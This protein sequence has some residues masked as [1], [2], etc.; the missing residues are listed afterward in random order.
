MNIQNNQLYLG[1]I[2][3]W[4]IPILEI[5][6]NSIKSFLENKNTDCKTLF[7]IIHPVKDFNLSSIL[8]QV[9]G[10]QDVFFFGE[11]P[12]E[13]FSFLG[14]DSVYDINI[15]GEERV[16]ETAEVVTAV[17]KNFVNNWKDYDLS[18][19]L[20][21]G[22]M[23]F[24][25]DKS[26]ELWNEFSDSDW[27]IPKFLFLKINN[28]PFLAYNILGN[29]CDDKRLQDDLNRASEL[30]NL[31]NL[32][33]SEI[34]NSII[35]TNKDEIGEKLRWDTNVNEALKR[36]E[37]G[38]VQKI[39]L[40]RQIQIGLARQGDISFIVKKLSKRYPGCYVFAYGKN[41]SIFFGASPEKLAKIS[42]GWVEADA[43]AGTT[44]RSDDPV[45]DER[46]AEDLLSSKK[47][48]AEQ[49]VVVS[50]IVKSF[51]KFCGEIVYEKQPIVRKLPN[52]QH[53]WTP[54]K[55]KLSS[56]KSI[57]AILKEIHPTPAICGV[58]WTNAL[59]SIKEMENHN[60]GLFSGMVGWFNFSNE[61]EFSVAIRSALM[62]GK[63]VYAFAGC[64]IVH[65]SDPDN[66]FEE[67]ELKLKPI[68]SLFENEAVY[69][70]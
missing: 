70:S 2:K 32:N 59:F 34:A 65:G 43:L 33:G 24:S 41:G 64:G 52:I 66:E 20:F 8:K 14:V 4:K 39:V 9:Q 61:G 51:S 31:T 12:D 42:D 69:Q 6:I 11:R 67:S 17:E 26:D 21:L 30:I 46:L 58:P 54:V 55:A 7:S 19:P 50:F 22:G 15:Q 57:F 23:K 60:R 49:R 25:V 47:N 13:K 62:K 40:S 3:I 27:F 5:Y 56:P 35:S 10:E 16:A 29:S 45:E 1:V 68:L 36:I 53:L 37:S 48:L 38:K 44:S 18:L 63:T 28:K